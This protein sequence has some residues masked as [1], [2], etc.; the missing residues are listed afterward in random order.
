MTTET[1]TLALARSLRAENVHSSLYH[2]LASVAYQER[3]HGFALVS[4]ISEQIGISTRGVHMTL[5][6]YRYF[7]KAAEPRRIGIPTRLTLTQEAIDLLVKI[8]RKTDQ[9]AARLEARQK[10]QHQTA[11]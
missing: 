4:R 5:H 3:A 8:K 2:I 6:H 11:A 1:F 7:F 10:P 9:N